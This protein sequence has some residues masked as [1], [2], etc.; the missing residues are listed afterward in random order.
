LAMTDRRAV[1]RTAVGI[2]PVI[3]G[4]AWFNARVYGSPL[5][6]GYGSLG[7][8]YALGNLPANIRLFATWTAD[9]QT[10]LVLMASLYFVMPHL[11]APDR[12]PAARVLLGGTLA[13][14]LS[15]YLFYQTFDVWWYLRFLLPMWPVLL[16]LTAAGIDAVA[17]RLPSVW[18]PLGAGLVVLLAAYGIYVAADRYA[19]DIGRGERRYVDVGRFV[20]SHTAPDAVVLSWQY[21]AAIR[22]YGGRLTLRYDT[23]DPAWLDRAIDHLRSSGRHPYLVL[24]EYEEALFRRRFAGSSPIGALAWQPM[25]VYLAP[26]IAVYDLLDRGNRETPIGIAATGRERARWRCDPPQ[27]WPPVL[28]MK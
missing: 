24:E 9:V 22:T 3:I 26:R 8:L 5:V 12:V 13:V 28:R 18:R 2:V 17:R 11:T 25:A 10:P 14:V 1:L 20:A 27:I 7:D 15:S 23:L 6:S 16:I 4:I 19:F 21:S